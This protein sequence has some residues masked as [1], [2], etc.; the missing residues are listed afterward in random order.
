MDELGNAYKDINQSIDIVDD[1]H[2]RALRGL[3]LLE[4]HQSESNPSP[5]S[6]VKAISDLT[7][8][9]EEE[10][11]ERLISISRLNSALESGITDYVNNFAALSPSERRFICFTDKI[12]AMGNHILVLPVGQLP[13][14][15]TFQEGLPRKN[16]IYEVHPFKPNHYISLDNFEFDM[17][18]DKMGEF[19]WIMENLG[20][21]QINII[22]E[23]N[24]EQT[25][26]QTNRR[27]VQAEGEY[28]DFNANG[29]YTED[30]NTE[31]F[32]KLHL[33]I[34]QHS[35]FLPGNEV[36]H[37]P[38]DLTW[39]PHLV[40][41]QKKVNSRLAG[42]VNSF[43]IRFESKTDQSLSESEAKQLEAEM[44][45]IVARA[46]GNIETTFDYH[47]S[48][49]ENHIW[50]AQ[51]DFYPLDCFAKKETNLP[52]S[53]SETSY[54]QL[55]AG[56]QEYMDTFKEIIQDGKITEK[57]RK[58][59]D[60]IGSKAGLSVE[61]IAELEASIIPPKKKSWWE[62]IFN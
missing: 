54:N 37:L 31:K 2:S 13:Q 58:L 42:R 26:S 4:I 35:K 6:I 9:F 19:Q 62:K 55:T 45:Y 52:E 56:E 8:I 34:E 16:V 23:S 51:V 7:S 22:V 47:I 28:S 40:D 10:H 49:S 46:K 21:R 39:Y 41:W 57:E 11:V 25:I 24:Q 61:R 12:Q 59:L 43:D 50:R 18:N 27:N 53:T 29:K 36:P 33:S 3:Y 14:G 30:Q 20:A 17:F 60:T 1:S 44:K 38:S 32:E 15:I 48:K 5:K